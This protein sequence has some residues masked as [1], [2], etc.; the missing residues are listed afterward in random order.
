M[1]DTSHNWIC[2]RCTGRGV[3]FLSCPVLQLP[4]P[5][6][7]LPAAETPNLVPSCGHVRAPHTD[8]CF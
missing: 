4:D 5:G 2:K 6:P 7:Y 1:A 8:R 3:H